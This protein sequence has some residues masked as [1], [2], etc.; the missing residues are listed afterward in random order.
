MLRRMAVWLVR[1]VYVGV[2]GALFVVAAYVAF[3]LFIRRGVTPVPSLVGLS[4]EEAEQ[5]L[6]DQGLVL[7]HD[8][9]EDRYADQVGAGQVLDQRPGGGSFAKRGGRIDVVLSRGRRR[10]TVPD[11]TGKALPAA[12]VTL[13]AVGLE[14]GRTAQVLAAGGGV[15]TV[16][17]QQPPAGAEV[18]RGAVVRL[19][20]AAEGEGETYV[21]PDLID[22]D[23][24]RVR[25]FL[26][27]N[28]F[29]VG[30]IKYEP[31]EGISRSV[32][33]RQFPLPG[34]PLHRSEAISLVV[35]AQ[36]QDGRGG[37]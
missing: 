16:V 2:V 18:D 1:L 35:A 29:R 3:S 13:S 5:R 11:L 21:M 26:E 32:V 28:G 12:Q 7:R 17:S 34:H 8:P 6:A 19:F 33:L 24:R 20:L 15:G 22:R 9:E 27:A 36:S 31:Y 23:Y 30:S 25:L 14:A 10:V 4:L 37:A